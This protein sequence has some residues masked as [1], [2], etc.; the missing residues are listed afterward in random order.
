MTMM[1]QKSSAKHISMASTETQF[2]SVGHGVSTSSPSYGVNDEEKK[3]TQRDGDLAST[4]NETDEAERATDQEETSPSEP[5][6]GGLRAWLQVV[7]GHL[8]VFNAWGYTISFGIFQPYYETEMNLPPSTV[9]WV[10]S[11]QI[12]L[13]FLVGT[14]SGRAFDAGYYRTALLVGCFLQVIVIFMTSIATEYWHLLLAQ[15]ICQGL[16]NGVVFAPTIANMSTYFSRKRTLAISSAACG[17]TTGGIV[18]PLIAQQLLP[19]IGFHWTVRVMGLVVMV[20][21]VLILSLA[22][23]RLP[24]R[25]AGPIV[26]LAAF[27]ESTYLLFAISMFFTLWATYYA[28]Y[29]VSCAA[30]ILMIQNTNM[31]I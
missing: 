22:R 17:G 15:G 29:Y 11:I 26:E 24:P 5:P 2:V 21:S 10:G 20:T 6:D 16:G 4:I 3:T 7:A 1:D 30:L 23:T 18:F 27:K 8:V 9:S 12:C 28:Y 31:S 19:K 25:K 13:I 14:F